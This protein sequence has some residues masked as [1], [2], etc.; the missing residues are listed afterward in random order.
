MVTR[1]LCEKCGESFL[2][3]QICK[4]HEK[5]CGIYIGEDYGD[6]F[7]FCR[8][9][10][11]EYLIELT[12]KKIILWDKKCYDVFKTTSIFGVI[13]F[14]AI[15]SSD[16]ILAI[17]NL[18]MCFLRIDNV[19]V[20]RKVNHEKKQL[21][22]EWSRIIGLYESIKNNIDVSKKQQEENK[23]VEFQIKE[24]I[25]KRCIYLRLYDFFKKRKG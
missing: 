6:N 10:F 5:F 13:E 11:I 21:N 12:N 19:I 20:I 9:S 14:E 1:Y 25:K 23:K 4:E 24:N 16:H 18:F 8:D 3:I 2:D 15:L 7:S 22:K 17:D